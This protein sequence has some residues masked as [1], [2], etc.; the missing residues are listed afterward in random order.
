MI[1]LSDLGDFTSDGTTLPAL[2]LYRCIFLY[3]FNQRFDGIL[4]RISP[5]IEMLHMSVHEEP[6]SAEC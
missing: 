2:K 4:A 1:F 5:H 6:F 3:Q